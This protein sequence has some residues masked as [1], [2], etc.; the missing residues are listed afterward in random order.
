MQPI[1]PMN[2]EPTPNLLAAIPASLP[3]EVV[4][5]LLRS[6][7]VRIERI[8]SRGHTSPELGWYDQDEH[9]WVLVVQGAAILGFDDGSE[10]RLGPGDHL[11]IPAHRRHRVGWTDPGQVTVWLAVF[12]R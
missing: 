2:A 10:V 3:T 1:P 9:E 5:E 4:T 8:L 12:Y 7:S 6:E 11:N